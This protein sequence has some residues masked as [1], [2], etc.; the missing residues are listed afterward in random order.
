MRYQTYGLTISSLAHAAGI[1]LIMT[2]CRFMPIETKA[3]LVDLTTFSVQKTAPKTA[4]P[5]PVKPIIKE[6]TP[7]ART[8]PAIRKITPIEPK[9]ATPAE[10]VEIAPAPL[11][12]FPATIAVIEEDM[13]AEVVRGPAVSA[14]APAEATAEA[15]SQRRQEYVK[16]HFLYIKDEIQKSIFYPPLAR[17]MGWEGRVVVSF[18]VCENG[19]ASNIRVVES[20]G[21]ALL[22][23]NAVESIIKAVPFPSPPVKAELVVPIIY[24]LG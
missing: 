6:K 1:F 11:E 19:T 2:F 14:D 10:L 23:K 12:P 17:K 22:D 9:P 21:F 15:K 7:V 16:A 20:S 5:L 8:K 18:V 4:S 3:L 13:P 24:R